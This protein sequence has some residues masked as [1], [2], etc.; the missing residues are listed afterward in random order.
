MQHS[1]NCVKG[2][3]H[4]TSQGKKETTKGRELTGAIHDAKHTAHEAAD[5]GGN[6]VAHRPVENADEQR[7]RKTH[8]EIGQLVPHVTGYRLGGGDSGS[9]S[10]GRGEASG[11][12]S[13]SK[14]KKTVGSAT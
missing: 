4:T 7:P 8:R 3:V 12:R 1:E 10:G 14:G 5:D 6:N 9:R 2:R 11:S 13:G